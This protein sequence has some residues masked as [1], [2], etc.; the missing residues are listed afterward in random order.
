VLTKHRVNAF[1]GTPLELLLRKVRG[2]GRPRAVSG[3]L[4]KFPLRIAA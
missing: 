1:V 2:R 3:A 4:E